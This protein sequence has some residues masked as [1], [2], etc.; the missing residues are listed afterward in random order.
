MTLDQL[1]RGD[2]LEV[3]TLSHRCL[4]AASF[5][6]LR[7]VIAS[8]EELTAFDRAVLLSVNARDGSL[9]HHVNYDFGEEWGTLYQQ[10]GFE[11]VDPV[12]LRA[13]LCGGPFRWEEAF[14]G[15]GADA[16]AGFIEA[17][18]DFGLVEGIAYGCAARSSPERTI[19]S[20]AAREGR[21]A[22]RA[23]ALVTAV[24]PHVHEAYDRLRFR[25]APAH[26]PLGPVALTAREREILA[27]TQ[28]G[29]TY[30]EIGKIIGISQ[31]TVK[32]HFA[33]IKQ[34]LDVVSVSHAVAKAMRL[35]LLE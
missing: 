16:S 25:S 4:A 9:T 2:L 19:L 11:R 20:L 26:S 29:K 1:P 14:A 35:G 32:Y 28:D 7:A 3:I 6:D 13:R 10:R 17:A 8:L 12:M 30:W 33:R 15:A 24:G 31:R 23:L 22:D 5:D 34:K 27:W 21:D 18:R